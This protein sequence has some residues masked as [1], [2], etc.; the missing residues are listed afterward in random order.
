LQANRKQAQQD[1]A[2]LQS[3]RQLWSELQDAET[4]QRGYILA[5]DPAYLDPYLASIEMIPV[6]IQELQN[7]AADKPAVVRGIGSLQ[8]LISTKLNELRSTIEISKTQG[9]DA[10][11][12][13]IL[14]DDGKLVMD[15]IR[16]QI[17][18]MVKE[19]TAEVR[20]NRV[21]LDASVDRA[22]FSALLAAAL[23]L[24]VAIG[25]GMALGRNFNRLAAAQAE[26]KDQA[27][28][29]QTTLDNTREGVAAFDP[30]KGL[31]AWNP[32]FF[33]FTG[34]PDD[35]PRVGR[36]FAEFLDFDRKRDNRLF[37]SGDDDVGVADFAQ[38]ANLR[39][40]V[41]VGGR[42]LECAHKRTQGGSIVMTC[43]D[44]TERLQTEQM[45]R[46]AQKMEAIG[47]LT[48]GVAHDFNNLLQVISSNLDLMA[49]N[50]GDPQQLAANIQHASIATE[51]GAQLT[52]QLLAFA[53]RQPLEPI[54]VNLGR[55]VRA[56][57][58]LLHRTLGETIEIETVVDA[59]LWNTFV[60]L[61]QVENA[62][63][64]LS[65][66]AR[67]AMPRGGKLTIELANAVLD[68]DYARWHDEVT[69]GQ[70]VMLAVTDTG[71]GMPADVAARAFEPFFTTKPEGKGTGLG[72][73]MVYGFVKQS[74]GHAKIYSEVGHGTTIKMYLPR[75][76]RPEETPALT[77]AEPVTGG[78]ERILLVE[79]D[80]DVR[81]AVAEMTRSLGYQVL[82]AKDGEQAM[83]MLQNG[84]TVD[85]L[86]T[87]VV[88]SGSVSGRVLANR[89]QELLPSLAVL[90]TSGYTENAIIHHGRLDEGVHL[91]SKPYRE[92]DLSRKIRTVLDLKR[93][94]AAAHRGR[95]GKDMNGTGLSILLVDD[96]A[97]IRMSTAGMLQDMGHSVLDAARGKEALDQLV[98]NPAINLLIVDIALPDM[99][100]VAL[101]TEASKIRPNLRVIFASGHSPQAVDLDPAKI[102]FVFLSKP[103]DTRQLADAL[104]KLT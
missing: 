16:A 70:Y 44:I 89:A 83:E 59:G 46:Q 95:E 51:R 35:F 57:S 63:L 42:E 100:G 79:D 9:F 88:M 32:R 13:R 71:S 15:K 3:I 94:D 41:R 14:A 60:D 97:L 28:L 85:L 22:R 96:D 91:L 93:R 25:G 54:V 87:D 103:Y 92:Q 69:P 2:T 29:L 82:E 73:S 80:E 31:I 61:N 90:F 81:R 77:D 37:E 75:S 84:T 58:D 53:R 52:R 26:L 24:I 1:S 30:V 19:F 74:S 33:S 34:Y 102:R 43:S 40:R 10:A 62:I 101:V 39:Q 4:G 8:E 67:D 49:R 64:N 50:K 104:A 98:E 7:L 55:R 18:S 72:L 86:F 23:G 38:M 99:N 6:Q 66:N 5:Q 45:V 12:R 17:E 47:H 78:S 65:V 20:E 48:G 76:R 21:L 68:E 56:M 27:S 36:G 11:R